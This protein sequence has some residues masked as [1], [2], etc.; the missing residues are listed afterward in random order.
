MWCGRRTRRGFQIPA[1]GDWN[2]ATNWSPASVPTGTA[3]FGFSNTTAISFSQSPL[4]VDAINFTNLSSQYSFALTISDGI[5]INLIVNGGGILG[6]S[7][8]ATFNVTGGGLVFDNSATAGNASINN[9]F[10]GTAGSIT[11]FAGSSTAGSATIVNSGAF[12]ETRFLINSSAGVSNIL[13][14]HGGTTSFSQTSSAGNATIRVNENPNINFG[15]NVTFSDNSSAANA[16]I[17]SNA[18]NVFF[19]V[20]STAASATITKIGG[21]VLFRDQSTADHAFISNN[22]LFINGSLNN[23]GT[24]VFGGNGAP[25]SAGNSTIQNNAGF[26]LFNDGSNATNANIV[27]DAGHLELHLQLNS[28]KQHYYKHQ[29][30]RDPFSRTQSYSWAGARHYG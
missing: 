20:Q 18:G 4:P 16:T 5:N 11:G 19:N 21:T 28:W 12:A 13:N 1:S 30:R 23:F 10:I 9:I 15:A 25:T 2:T 8:L 22:N 17:I 27:N 14:E 29:R 6:N 24:I 7:S 26:V 3:T